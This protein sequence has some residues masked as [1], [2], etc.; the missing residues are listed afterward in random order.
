[1]NIS[2]VIKGN[3]VGNIS[4]AIC[5]N[6]PMNISTPFESR[7]GANNF[8]FEEREICTYVLV[9]APCEREVCPYLYQLPARERFVHISTGSLLMR[10]LY[11]FVPASCEREICTYLYKL[12]VR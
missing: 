5:K 9:L 2:T 10:D 3:I 7:A 12:L 8:D 4:T 11:I 1:M 6:I